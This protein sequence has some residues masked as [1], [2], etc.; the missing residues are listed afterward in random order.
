[1]VC[2]NDLSLDELTKAMHS[3]KKGK[4]PGTDGLTI[5]FYAY[6]WEFIK[7]PLLRMYNECII[8]E[9]LCTSMKQGLITLI[10]KAGKDLLSLDNWRPITLLNLDYKILSLVL[11]KRLKTGLSDII[12]ETQTGFMPRQHISSYI[13]LILDLIDYANYIN[14]DAIIL[15]LDFY[16]AFDTIEH[17]FL[18]STLEFGFGEKFIKMV[19]MIYKD[20]NSSVLLQFD[21][22]NR[23]PINRG[24]RQESPPFCSY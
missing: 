9:E 19:K 17:K 4:S 14:S 8:N 24:V 23:F 1:M 2:E 18:F 20:I 10:P 12:N 3:M 5:E 13:R 15:F 16:K 21:T 6:F 22:S 11:A 7:R